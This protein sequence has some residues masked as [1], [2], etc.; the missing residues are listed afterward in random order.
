MSGAFYKQPLLSLHAAPSPGSTV[1]G[2]ILPEDV[3]G[4][5]L[6]TKAIYS[7]SDSVHPLL[8]LCRC[9]RNPSSFLLFR[10]LINTFV[11]RWNSA[12]FPAPVLISVLLFCFHGPVPIPCGTELLS[13]GVQR[14]SHLPTS[15]LSSAHSDSRP[16]PPFRHHFLPHVKGKEAASALRSGDL[17]APRQG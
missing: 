10:L 12:T 2:I 6:L 8:T 1:A 14:V 15:S 7:E 13:P 11:P 17:L 4:P 3:L 16:N 9:I 5:F